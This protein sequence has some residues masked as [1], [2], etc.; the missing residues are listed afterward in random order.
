MHNKTNTNT[1]LPQTMGSAFNN[2]LT[3]TEQQLCLLEEETVQPL[4]ASCQCT[5]VSD[6]SQGWHCRAVAG[7]HTCADPEGVRTPS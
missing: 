7:Q 3:T 2:R 6:Y 5:L 4:L 1:Q